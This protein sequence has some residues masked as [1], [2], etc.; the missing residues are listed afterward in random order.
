MQ[1]TRSTLAQLRAIR[2][3]RGSRSPFQDHTAFLCWTDEAAPLL[4]FNAALAQEF[5]GNV[6]SAKMLFG[7]KEKEGR[8]DGAVS[9]AIG[10]VNKAIALL[11]AQIA[12]A[13]E[14]PGVTAITPPLVA[15]ER[16]TIRWLVDHVP[17]PSLG[18]GVALLIST[19][20]AG[21]VFSETQL[22]ALL[23]SRVGSASTA[24]TSKAV[25]PTESDP[26]KSPS[27]ASASK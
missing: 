27:A 8:Y 7:W 24:A 4:S 1:R 25:Y 3:D 9:E 11:E 20:G 22:Y 5:A 21:V 26:S 2:Q 16:V 18:G 14:S 23:K 12:S 15:P 13:T 6:H 17:V 10:T 19:F